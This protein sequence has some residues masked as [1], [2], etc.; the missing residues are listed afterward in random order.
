MQDDGV[1]ECPAHGAQP[2][3]FVC[4][5]LAASVRTGEIVGYVA[6]LEDESAARPHAWCRAYEAIRRAEGGEWNDRSEAYAGVTL[7]CGRRYDEAR[8]PNA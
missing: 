1:V 7:I 8:A 4:R 2:A 5:H 3:C 6:S